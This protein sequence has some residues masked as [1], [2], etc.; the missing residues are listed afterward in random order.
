MLAKE[1]ITWIVQN[2][3]L[4]FGGGMSLAS[5]GFATW[6]WRKRRRL[7]ESPLELGKIVGQIKALICVHQASAWGPYSGLPVAARGRLLKVEMISD[8][9]ICVMLECYR[10][11]IRVRFCVSRVQ[12]PRLTVAAERTKL[13]VVGKLGRMSYPDVELTDITTVEFL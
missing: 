8:D 7:H 10:H 1:F 2:R 12:Y 3:D 6:R 11:R 9:L 4:L 13:G 5:L